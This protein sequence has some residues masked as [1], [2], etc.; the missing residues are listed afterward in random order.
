MTKFADNVSGNSFEKTVKI[1]K[2]YLLFLYKMDRDNE[3]KIKSIERTLQSSLKD[4]VLV[5]MED[6][7]EGLKAL[8]VKNIE[9]ILID[10]SLLKKDEITIEY[11]LHCKKRRRCPILFI[12]PT[13][14]NLI[15][16]YREKMYAYQEFDNYFTEPMDM[17]EFQKKVVQLTKTSI[18]AAK[19]FSLEIPVQ[20]FRLDNNQTY[21]MTLMDI[22]LVGFG[23]KYVGAE[24]FN[25]NE[26][27]KI[28]MPLVDFKIFHEEYG[29]Y[30]NIAGKLRRM[31][32]AGQELGFSIEH[33]TPSQTEMLFEVLSVINSNA[34]M[35]TFKDNQLTEKA[36]AQS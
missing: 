29:E 27:V 19:R 6:A 22:S 32:I 25:I 1:K 24:N 7:E 4:F 26:Q 28:K 5:R 33:A 13:P 18:R 36:A 31:S 23:V 9:L 17:S 16:Y 2:R 30:I 3:Q 15:Q 12:T 35:R 34:R 10:S 8:M 11:A 14:T 21:F 20:V